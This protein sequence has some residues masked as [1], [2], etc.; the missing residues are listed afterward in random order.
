MGINI[1]NNNEDQF[2][3]TMR[4]L[5]QLPKVNAPDDF[6]FNLMI[7]ITNG[8]LQ[9]ET[10]EKRQS[11][12]L[13]ILGPAAL[14]VTTV[15]L[16]VTFSKSELD[17]QLNPLQNQGSIYAGKIGDTAAK[18]GV[19]KPA[20]NITFKKSI[21]NRTTSPIQTPNQNPVVIP[22]PQLPLV[23][24]YSGSP[25]TRQ[26]AYRLD[27]L[28]KG[29]RQSTS[30]STWAAKNSNFGGEDIPEELLLRVEKGQRDKK[31][32]QDSLKRLTDSLKLKK[33]IKR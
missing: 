22:D 20:A 26:G 5:R 3:E 13:W 32:V 24:N 1:Y 19:Q 29:T 10:E 31:A 8:E 28:L 11:K 9:P 30:L 27:N 2:F 18:E 25:L 17:Q 4:A 23:G 21:P 6:E 14:V 16:F 12:I 7:K 33:N 15:I